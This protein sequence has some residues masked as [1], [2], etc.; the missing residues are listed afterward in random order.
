MAPLPFSEGSEA[1][2]MQTS[3]RLPCCPYCTLSIASQMTGEWIEPCQ[4]CRRPIVALALPFDPTPRVRLYSL[5]GAAMSLYGVATIGMLFVFLASQMPASTFARVF[6]LL[7]FIIGSVLLVDGSLA[8]RTTIDR[9]WGVI[10]RGSAALWMGIAK[11]LAGVL[12]LL[13]TTIGATV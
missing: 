6:S 10:R 4:Q 5:F 9:T 7:L 1:T 3:N 13:L 2:M 11:I 8:T 12:A